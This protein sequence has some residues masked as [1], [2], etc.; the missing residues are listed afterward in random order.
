[1][2]FGLE[3]CTSESLNVQS[4]VQNW[5]IVVQLSFLKE[6]TNSM[7]PLEQMVRQEVVPDNSL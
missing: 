5:S 1:M 3:S 2:S 6:I 7:A 4:G